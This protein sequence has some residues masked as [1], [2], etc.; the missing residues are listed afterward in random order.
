MR[1]LLVCGPYGSGTSAVAG[2]LANMGA[3][4]VGPYQGTNDPR[5]PNAFESIAFRATVLGL[6]SETTMLLK[7]GA[8]IEA[9]LLQLKSQIAERLPEGE[10]RPIFLKHPAAAPIIPHICELFDTKLIYV[11]RATK[12]IEATRQRRN[13][14]N[15]G[16]SITRI[17]YSHMFDHLVNGRTPT[18][19]V[20]YRSLIESPARHA[21]ELAAFAGLQCDEN[22]LQNA[23]HFVLSRPSGA[24]ATSRLQSPAPPNDLETD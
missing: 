14:P 21:K 17:I 16:E 9:A 15:E 11:L 22:A 6:V 18:T 7:P 20:R 12:D 13:W 2:M 8:A 3:I 1:L 19:L 23:A 4:G 5:T 10:M 24:S